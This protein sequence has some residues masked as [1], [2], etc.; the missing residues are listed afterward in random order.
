MDQGPKLGRQ[1][2]A[3]FDGKFYTTVPLKDENSYHLQQHPHLLPG[4]PE[5]VEGAG[6]SL[7]NRIVFKGTF[8]RDLEP[9][10]S[11]PASAAGAA[12]GS[13]GGG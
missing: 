8:S 9:Y 6:S 7:H 3:K 13:G 12:G 2:S 10:A 1:K 4:R 5:E 11:A